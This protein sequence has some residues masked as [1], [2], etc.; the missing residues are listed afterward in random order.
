MSYPAKKK[1][2]GESPVERIIDFLKTA[3]LPGN[4]VTRTGEIIYLNLQMRRLIS[5]GGE[6][7]CYRCSWLA[8]QEN[9]SC[10][11]CAEPPV[12][13]GKCFLTRENRDVT[14]LAAVRIPQAD[15]VLARLYSE[16]STSN[17]FN[18]EAIVS[19]LMELAIPVNFYNGSGLLRLNEDWLCR[20]GL[21]DIVESAIESQKL[22]P[23]KI[24][25]K[26]DKKCVIKA[27]NP[28]IISQTIRKILWELR[29][30]KLQDAIT[31]RSMN[32]AASLNIPNS[33]IV[34]FMAK[35]SKT[36]GKSSASELSAIGLRLKAFCKQLSQTTS[37]YVREPMVFHYDDIVELQ[38]PIPDNLE[39]L[40]GAPLS[41]NVGAFAGISSREQEIVEMVRMGYDNES[42][43]N[44]LGITHATVKQHLKAIYRKL[45]VKNRIELIF[46]ETNP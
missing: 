38:F 14:L 31:I 2:Y 1:E 18:E 10:P 44:S 41:S 39:K 32:Q 29:N 20:A 21:W 12:L 17:M 6:N 42:I 35:S 9:E 8:S 5:S 24:E 15:N 27:T 43:S 16:K 23:L 26:V 34:T 36:L 37:Y 46:K 30:M 19:R 45:D 4:V 25:N 28:I 22:E 33:H 13:E 7:R 3:P 11:D 40:T